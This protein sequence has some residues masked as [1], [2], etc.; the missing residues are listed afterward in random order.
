MWLV[1]YNQK[2]GRKNW[3]TVWMLT[4][5]RKVHKFFSTSK[6]RTWK[7]I[8]YKVRII[9]SLRFMESSLSN[10]ADNPC[11]GLHNNK[12]KDCKSCFAF[13]KFR[14]ELLI[15]NCSGSNKN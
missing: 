12:Y 1:F 11:E 3:K 14:D 6:A 10:L 4:R 9:D 15:F 8:T 2:V 7:T 5:H 13:I